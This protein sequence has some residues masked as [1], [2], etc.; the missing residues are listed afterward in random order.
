MRATLLMTERN[1]RF[2]VP[3]PVQKRSG[4]SATERDARVSADLTWG[5]VTKIGGAVLFAGALGAAFVQWIAGPRLREE[6]RPVIR[7]EAARTVEARL[8]TMRREL[9]L[10]YDQLLEAIRELKEK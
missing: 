3:A 1:G 5:T 2:S 8:A 10:K 6:M 9:D 7:D 4:K